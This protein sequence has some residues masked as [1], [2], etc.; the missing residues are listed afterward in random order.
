MDGMLSI[1]AT[2]NLRRRCTIPGC[3][4]QFSP[5]LGEKKRISLRC[6][7]RRRRLGGTQTRP[8]ALV[9]FFFSPR[10]CGGNKPQAQDRPVVAHMEIFELGLWDEAGSGGEE[11]RMRRGP[12][13]GKLDDGKL[14]PLR[15]GFLRCCVAIGTRTRHL[16][17]YNPQFAPPFF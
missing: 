4:P 11:A 1:P 3:G 13:S 10:P 15:S 8:L 2:Q 12:T 7:N 17:F 6:L 5:G 9:L 14:G 16:T